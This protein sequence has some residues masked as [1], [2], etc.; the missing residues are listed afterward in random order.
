M[1][2][3]ALSRR[4]SGARAL[5]YGL[6]VT[7]LSACGGNIGIEDMRQRRDLIVLEQRG[8]PLTEPGSLDCPELMPD[9]AAGERFE[10]EE[11]VVSAAA[12]CRSRLR[13]S[14]VDLG[15]CDSRH[16]ARDLEEFRI[17]LGGRRGFRQWNVVAT[18]CGTRLALAALDGAG[19]HVRGT[20]AASAICPI[21]LQDQP[22]LPVPA[23]VCSDI[24]ILLT[25]GQFDPVTPA[26]DVGT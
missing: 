8:T 18:S 12:A 7:L 16:S 26:T 3:S 4:P 11:E 14:G 21:W 24:A 19:R 25:V 10:A 17:L 1:P 6:L 5:V 2:A 23:P 20:R 13:S 22:R 15:A 9:D